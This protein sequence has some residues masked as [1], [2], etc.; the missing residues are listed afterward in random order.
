M[1]TINLVLWYQFGGI[2]WRESFEEL[3]ENLL[4][5]ICILNKLSFL[6]FAK[7]DQRLFA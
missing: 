6:S 2:S 7:C 5:K 4:K 3:L 1:V